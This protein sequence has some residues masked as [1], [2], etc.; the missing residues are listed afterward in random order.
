MQL[1]IT[2]AAAGS[3]IYGFLFLL[4]GRRVTQ[5][6]FVASSQRL[7]A[8]KTKTRVEFVKDAS[9]RTRAIGLFIVSI[10]YTVI[11]VMLA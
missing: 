4:R 5:Y 7:L 10:I 3:C 6:D 9:A 2:L 8:K 11:T 1:L